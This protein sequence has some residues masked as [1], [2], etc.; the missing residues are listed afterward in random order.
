MAQSDLKI[1]KN[2]LD[3]SELLMGYNGKQEYAVF[4]ANKFITA[5]WDTTD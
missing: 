4:E 3:V 1:G 5:Q 2:A